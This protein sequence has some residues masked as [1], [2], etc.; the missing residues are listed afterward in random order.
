M[1]KSI[2]ALIRHMNIKRLFRL[3]RD[4]KLLVLLSTMSEIFVPI[5]Y[6]LVCNFAVFRNYIHRFGKFVNVCDFENFLDD[7]KSSFTHVNE[8]S[9]RIEESSETLGSLGQR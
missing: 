5:F 8:F 6:H 9:S 4:D 3:M 2:E 7:Y 1:I